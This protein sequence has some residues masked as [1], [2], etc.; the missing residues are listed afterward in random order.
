MDF[1][2]WFLTEWCIAGGLISHKTAADILGKSNSRI[3]QMI[4]EGVLTRYSF[5]N[6]T[7]VSFSEVMNIANM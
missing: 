1:Y 3:T 4:N 5:E 2:S 6:K 7:F